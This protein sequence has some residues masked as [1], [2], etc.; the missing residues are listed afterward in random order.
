MSEELLSATFT[1]FKSSGKFYTAEKGLIRKDWYLQPY[2]REFVK[3][4]NDGSMPGLSTDGLEFYIVID[5]P[6]S[7][8]L[9]IRP[10]E[11]E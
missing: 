6:E 2:T 11:P 4:D 7:Y 3:Q 1:Y 10:K 5:I 9:L 8:P